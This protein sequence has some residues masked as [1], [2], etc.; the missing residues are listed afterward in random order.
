NEIALQLERLKIKRNNIINAVA[1]GMI[2]D[3][4]RDI[5][6]RIKADEN[7][8]LERQ[9]SLTMRDTDI[10]ISEEKLYEAISVLSEYVYE[11]DI[12]ECKKFIA[13]YVKS[14][15]VYDTK[16]EVTVTIPSELLCGCEYCITKSLGRTFLPS[17]KEKRLL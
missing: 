5:L 8:C 2:E 3:D 12:P 14:V 11:R 16:V 1:D 9:K 17:P 4:F 15:T 6:A 10:N 13:Q 7:S